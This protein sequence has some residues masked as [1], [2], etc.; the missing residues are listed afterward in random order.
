MRV[1]G[2]T[3]Y[4][5]FPI[6]WLPPPYSDLYISGGGYGIFGAG[7]Q[8]SPGYAADHFTSAALPSAETVLPVPDDPDYGLRVGDT[9]SSTL[10]ANPTLFKATDGAHVSNGHL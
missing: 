6:F 7:V 5:L 10:E 4:V 1:P 9:M 8:A 2:V 3:E